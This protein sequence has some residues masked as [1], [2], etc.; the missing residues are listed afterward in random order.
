MALSTKKLKPR[1]LAV[2]LVRQVE[3]DPDKDFSLTVVILLNSSAD[4]E[5]VAAALQEVGAERLEMGRGVM[6][7][8]ISSSKLLSLEKIEHVISIESPQLYRPKGD[9]PPKKQI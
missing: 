6:T 7:V 4:S 3:D 1:K 8:K 5:A 9:V 2:D